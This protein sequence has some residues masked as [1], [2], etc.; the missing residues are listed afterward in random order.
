[1]RPWIAKKITEYFGEGDETA[2][3]IEYICKKISEHSKP[4][5]V[6]D[7]LKELLDEAETFVVRMWRMLIFEMLRCSA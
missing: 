6:L 4:L 5:E 3:L 2:A 7:Q 1:M